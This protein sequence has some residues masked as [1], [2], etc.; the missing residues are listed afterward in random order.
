M[1]LSRLLRQA[2]EALEVPRD[3]ALGRYPPFVTGGALPK[4][5]VPVFVFHSVEP[6]SFGRKLQHL[7]DN[8]YRTL[9]AAEYYEGLTGTKPFP[10][11]AVLLTFDDGRGSL[12]SVGAPLL[13]RHGMRGV[14]FLV[15]GRTGSRPGP[16][17]P[18]LDDLDEGGSKDGSA[19]ALLAEEVFG[20][21]EGDRAFLSWEE[22]SA[23][24]RSEVFE[25]ESHSLSHAR[26]H[27]APQVAGFLTPDARRGYAA[28]DVPL[29]REGARDL[30][31]ED[32]PLGT[33]LLR[34]ASRLSEETRF[35]EDPAF[36]T[37]CVGAVAAEGGHEFFRRRD[38]E[39]RLRR[40]VPRQPI[41]GRPESPEERE[42]A[43]RRELREARRLI[44]EHTSREVAHLC[45]PWHVSGPTSRRLAR[46]AGYRTAF[47]G[48]V[49]GVP[50]T[51][52][53]GDP[54]AIARVGE[55]YVELLPGRGRRGVIEVLRRKWAR[56]FR[57]AAGRGP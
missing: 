37:A 22:V 2:G 7:S 23:L 31:A 8:G 20:R 9:S 43:L 57:G 13:R 32:V 55:D 50:I 56:R 18:T 36:R 25:F 30:F 17:P 44:A 11:K 16:L 28:M 33:P 35:V 54:L 29:I 42:A 14:V 24:A 3:L 41:G 40:L 46:E 26:I 52:A 10:D 15:P 21:E 6:E 4:G 45:Y 19:K 38:W 27:V 1:P 53:G 47:C 5:D 51:R 39:A 34:S 49:P 48:K 12:W